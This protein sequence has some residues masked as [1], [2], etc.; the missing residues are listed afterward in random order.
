MQVLHP[1]CAALDLGKDVLA[2]AVR[3]QEK[4]SVRRECRSYGMNTSQLLM[5]SSWLLSEGVT[6]VVMEATGSYWK[7]VWQVLEGQFELVLANPVHIRNLPGR[8]SDVNDATWMADLLAHGLIQ[9]SFVPPAPIMVLRELTRTR[10]QLGR[11]VARHTQR[12]QRILDVA[13]LKITGPI[14]DLLGTS[15]RAVLNGLIGGETDPEKLADLVHPRLQ[16]KRAT[17]VEALR[18]RLTPHQRGLLRIHLHLTETVEL[19]IA[20]LDFEIEKAVQP[21]RE[22]LARLKK[23]HGFGEV[24][25]PALLG[26]IGV[27]MSPFK[28]HRHLVSWARLA[29]RLDQSAGKTHSTRTLKGAVWVKPLLIGAAWAAVKVKNG[30]P[31]AQYLRLRARRGKKKA[32]VAVA[33][34]LLTAIYHMIRE[35]T[36]YR[37]LGANH[38][39]SHDRA[40]T[41]RRLVARLEQLGYQAK[42]TNRAA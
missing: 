9:G 22:L 34:S 31:R 16:P 12:I 5:L 30:Y 38:F 6:H 41:A 20:E 35:G 21:F 4:G 15:G 27:D 3:L 10:K 1:R 7:A 23:V 29:P 33:A 39:D 13:G 26:E 37:D 14:S 17:L 40:R 28:T 19:S 11:E 36:P 2:S 18:G 24:N 25:A 42:V 32:I 8:K